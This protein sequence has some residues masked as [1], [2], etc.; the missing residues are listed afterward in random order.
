[1]SLCKKSGVH[2]L[3]LV[4]SLS[5]YLQG[6]FPSKR[7]LALGFFF[8]QSYP[9]RWLPNSTGIFFCSV[10]STHDLPPAFFVWED[11]SEIHGPWILPIR[12]RN[13]GITFTLPETN[14]S[15]LKI[16]LPKRKVVF[17]PSI[18]R[19]YVSLREGMLSTHL[20]SQD[21][22]FDRFP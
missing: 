8:H 3:R 22:L 2:Q 21:S 6:F 5:R 11:F 4:V 13:L 1:M 14:S 20:P 16:G 15:P 17:Q 7:W 18:F 9:T 10:G 19:G 12:I